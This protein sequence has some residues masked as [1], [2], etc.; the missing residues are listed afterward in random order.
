MTVLDNT[1]Q[2]WPTGWRAWLDQPA[3]C[4]CGGTLADSDTHLLLVYP[5]GGKEAGHALLLCQ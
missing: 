5:G 4:G 3:D 1:A 2:P